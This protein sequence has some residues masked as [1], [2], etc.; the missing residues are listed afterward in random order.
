MHYWRITSSTTDLGDKML[1][2]PVLAM[3][4][5]NSNS[6]HYTTLIYH[7]LNDYKMAN[8]GKQGLCMVSFDTELYGHW[9]FEGVEFIKQVIKKLNQFLPEVEIMI[10]G[11]YLKAH[12]PVDAIQTP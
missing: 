4:Q 11:E 10:S 3:N 2:D 12:P 7:L 6:D 8:N 1:Y 5:I 9:W